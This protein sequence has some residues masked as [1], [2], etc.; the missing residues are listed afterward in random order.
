MSHQPGIARPQNFM[1][2]Q[3][4]QRAHLIQLFLSRCSHERSNPRNIYPAP[5][6]RLL[7]RKTIQ[8]S[9]PSMRRM[10][11]FMTWSRRPSAGIS[12][13]RFGVTW[14]GYLYM[15]YI[16]SIYIYIYTRNI[17]VCL[18]FIAGIFVMVL[19]HPRQALDMDVEHEEKSITNRARDFT[20]APWPAEIA[21]KGKP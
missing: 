6:D 20:K 10:L 19:P 15:V 11:L 13:Q 8:T 21:Q 14:K 1:C 17:H 16:Y 9:R 4:H 3:K 18:S 2:S 7:M 5:L 12:P